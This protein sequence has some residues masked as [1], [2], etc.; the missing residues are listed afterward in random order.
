VQARVPIPRKVLDPTRKFQVPQRRAK[1]PRVL[2]A[3]AA[4]GYRRPRGCAQ[5]RNGW[6]RGW[7]RAPVPSRRQDV[8]CSVIRSAPSPR[9]RVSPSQEPQSGDR[10]GENCGRGPQRQAQVPK[11]ANRLESVRIRPGVHARRAP[12]PGVNASRSQAARSSARIGVERT[13][14]VARLALDQEVGPTVG[15][16]ASGAED[17]ASG[18]AKRSPTAIGPVAETSRPYDMPSNKRN[19]NT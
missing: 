4:R 3:L 13:L 10:D 1:F 19:T 14:G 18:G 9:R 17:L 15:S 7:R 12:S 11:A 5:V 16:G 6:S 8:P 2:P